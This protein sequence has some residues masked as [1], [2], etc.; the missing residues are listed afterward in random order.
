V[1]VEHDVTIASTPGGSA[2]AAERQT[3]LAAAGLIA[4]AAIVAVNVFGRP[5]ADDTRLVNLQGCPDCAT[6]VAVRQAHSE[7]GA[8]FV[9]IQLRDGS[10]RTLRGRANGFSVGDVVEVKGDALTLRDAF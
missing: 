1:K 2:T 6:V 3:P 4:I 5:R 8:T 7:E 10:R 9:E